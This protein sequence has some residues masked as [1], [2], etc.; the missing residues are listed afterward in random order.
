M[1]ELY[2]LIPLLLYNLFAFFLMGFDKHRAIHKGRRVRERT[3][4]IF[5]ALLAGVGIWLGMTVYRHK[6]KHTAFIWWVPIITILEYGV[7][8][9]LWV[10]R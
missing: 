1:P 3:L 10:I 6:T 5:T 9:Y 8:I 4:F 7:L 2:L